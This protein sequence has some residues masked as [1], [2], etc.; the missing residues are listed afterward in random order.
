MRLDDFSDVMSAVQMLNSKCQAPS[1]VGRH[2]V[3]G[4]GVCDIS[5]Y[6]VAVSGRWDTTSATWQQVMMMMSKLENNESKPELMV[7]Q[8]YVND[9]KSRQLLRNPS[10]TIFAEK[11]DK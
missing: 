10:L 3:A 6:I 1:F 8:K 9:W 4:A 2:E 11:D 5:L 7:S